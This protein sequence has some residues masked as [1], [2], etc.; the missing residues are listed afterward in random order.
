MLLY[1]ADKIFHTFHLIWIVRDFPLCAE[2]LFQ[3]DHQFS[4]VKLVQSEIIGQARASIN[5]VGV[6]F[7]VLSDE[8]TD[9]ACKGSF[10]ARSSQSQR[11]HNTP[12]SPKTPYHN[13][14]YP[15]SNVTIR[16][17]FRTVAATTRSSGIDVPPSSIRELPMC[18]WPL[19]A[20]KQSWTD[21][22]FNI[23]M[24]IIWFN[25]CHSGVFRQ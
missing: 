17:N 8:C 6:N 25:R 14:I 10:C 2:C 5:R 4:N 15:V 23:G 13:P 1:V 3:R 20:F 11:R 9:L 18:G 16:N 21:H 22:C 12:H 7:Q 24:Q 19:D